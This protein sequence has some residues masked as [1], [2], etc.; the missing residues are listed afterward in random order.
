MVHVKV[1]AALSRSTF[2]QIDQ[3]IVVDQSEKKSFR[4]IRL[5]RQAST[6]KYI[7]EP[8]LLLIYGPFRG[9]RR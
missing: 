6:G 9:T 7:N 2:L 8:F 3:T 4:S 5:N 1:T